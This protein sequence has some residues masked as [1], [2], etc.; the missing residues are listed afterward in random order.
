V[1]E[2]RPGAQRRIEKT[3]AVILS[4][5][6]DLSHPWAE[7]APSF[8]PRRSAPPLPA[9]SKRSFD[10]LRMTAFFDAALRAKACDAPHAHGLPYSL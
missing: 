3:N 10:K 8:E 9:K 7:A 6:K 5:S 4:L 2:E 1:E